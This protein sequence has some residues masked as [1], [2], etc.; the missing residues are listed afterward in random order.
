MKFPKT[1]N[2]YC[3]FCK[4]HTEHKVLEGKKKGRNDTHP[5]SRGSRQR[6][7]HRGKLGIG[8]HGKYSMPPILSRRMFGRK[9]SKK[10]D[11]RFECSGCKKMHGMANGG[12]RVRKIEF[13]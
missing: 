9:T 7:K 4:K 8:N 6:L 13:K 11:F 1:R 12:F 5:M 10:T 3:P 2:K